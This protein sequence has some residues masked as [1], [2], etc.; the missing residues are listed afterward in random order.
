MFGRGQNHRFNNPEHLPAKSKRGREEGDGTENVINCRDVC[1]K[2]SWHFMT[3]YDDLWR[4]MSMEQRDGKC[5]KM[6]QVV[7]QCRKLS[8]RLSQIVVTFFSRPLP[9]V[10]FWFSPN[11]ASFF[12]PPKGFF[13][14]SF[15]L[16]KAQSLRHRE[17]AISTATYRGAKC[18]T[19]KT[20][21]KQ[22]KRVSSG[23]RR[24]NRKTTKT[25]VSTRHFDV[26]HLAPL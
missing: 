21:E 14:E 8:W 3:T 10:P 18:P 20:A 22:P 15:W 23:S 1:R 13:C 5:H 16:E 25:H 2:L 24:N 17:L 12:W 6:S 19:S 9:A 4:F 11:L 26:G 7:V